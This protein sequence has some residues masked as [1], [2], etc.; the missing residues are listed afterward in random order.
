MTMRINQMHVTKV[1]IFAARKIFIFDRNI[2]SLSDKVKVLIIRFSSIGDVVLTTPVVRCLK[3][4]LYGESK[5]HY[6]VKKQFVPVLE[7]N[8]YI[9]V[10]H[11]L[12]NN[13]DSIIK[14]LIKE[15]FH[16]IID[17]HKNIRS[18]YFRKKLKALTFT[19]RKLNIEKWILVNFKIDLLPELHIVDRYFEAVKALGI[20]NDLEG[21]DF[22]LSPTDFVDTLTEFGHEKNTFIAFAIGGAHSGKKLSSER[23]SELCG[24]LAFPIILV[25][26]KEDEELG[27]KIAEKLAHVSSACGKLTI[28]QSAS[29]IEQA[30]L[31]IC[32]DSGMMHI[33]SAFK[34][35]IISIWGATVPKFGM[36]PYLPH[37]DS[38]MIQADHL[39]FRPTSKLGNRNSKKERRTTD[40]I[41]L[42]RI[43]EAVEKLMISS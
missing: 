40:E 15:D 24:I 23:I 18:L 33:A 36:Y 1:S 32:H 9:D 2:F 8:P 27:N 19:I 26:G 11:V 30:S 38:V 37:P 5:I 39:K 25:G 22:F 16:Y 7:G 43:K 42:N 10:I 41:D 4:Q 21:I 12:D 35:K 13:A 28:K 20:K 17:L 31:V 14:E 34:K 29:V 3:K 6:L